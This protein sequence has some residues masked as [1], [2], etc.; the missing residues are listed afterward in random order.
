MGDK[1]KMPST[2]FS[3]AETFCMLLRAQSGVEGEQVRGSRER[4]K[5]KKYV[6]QNMK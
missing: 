6:Y 2:T 5:E 4:R 3:V 1:I